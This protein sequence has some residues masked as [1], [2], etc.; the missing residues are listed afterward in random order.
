MFGL[1]VICWPTWKCHNRACFD[2]KFLK[3]PSEIIFSACAFMRY[4]AGLHPVETQQLVEGY[5]GFMD[6]DI[7]DVPR[8]VVDT[9]DPT[10]DAEAIAEKVVGF[11]RSL[12]GHG[13]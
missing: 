2:K 11:V 10:V 6:Y 8:I 13:H 9:T 12:L 3:N 1:A 4:W 7:E 5:Q